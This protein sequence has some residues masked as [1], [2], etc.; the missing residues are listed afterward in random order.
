MRVLFP[1]IRRLRDSR[2]DSSDIACLHTRLTYDPQKSTQTSRFPW[3]KATTIYLVR[4]VAFWASRL[5]C[6]FGFWSS[7][8]T[9][10]IVTHVGG[11]TQTAR[12][13]WLG[14]LP[15]PGGIPGFCLELV[16]GLACLGFAAAAAAFF[17]SGLGLITTGFFTRGCLGK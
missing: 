7:F 4:F 8:T 14:A 2:P 1:L 12:T 17:S 13:F 15:K 6:L 5:S 3:L 11:W 10:G 16:C 9:R